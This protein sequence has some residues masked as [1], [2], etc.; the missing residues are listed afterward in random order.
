MN[1][2]NIWEIICEFTEDPAFSLK[3][4]ERL[5]NLCGMKYKHVHIDKENK[6]TIAMDA[7]NIIVDLRAKNGDE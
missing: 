4:I 3:R 6:L 1:N 7:F 5:Q 2:D